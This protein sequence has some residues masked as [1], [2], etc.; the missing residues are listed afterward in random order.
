MTLCFLF[1]TTKVRPQQTVSKE[2]G[3]NFHRTLRRMAQNATSR[4]DVYPTC[5][6]TVVMVLSWLISKGKN[7]EKNGK[8]KKKGVI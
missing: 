5:R 7:I 1:D 3:F 2:K 6:E 8:C 4:A